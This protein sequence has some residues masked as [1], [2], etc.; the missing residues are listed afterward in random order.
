VEVDPA[1]F[2]HLQDLLWVAVARYRKCGHP[3]P[4]DPLEQDLG[5]VG[6]TEVRDVANE[7]KAVIPPF[8]ELGEVLF[9]ARYSV[10]VG[11]Y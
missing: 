1:L 3:P 10:K 7:Y 4:L 6:W 2:E 5:E 8:E 11:G 9:G